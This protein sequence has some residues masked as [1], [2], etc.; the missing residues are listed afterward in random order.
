MSFCL[1]RESLKQCKKHHCAWK[2][3]VNSSY[4]KTDLKL[5]TDISWFRK[6]CSLFHCKEGGTDSSAVL[7]EPTAAFI[8]LTFV[9]LNCQS[10]SPTVLNRISRTETKTFTSMRSW[11]Q[12]RSPQAHCSCGQ[13]LTKPQTPSALP[14][15]LIM[16]ELILKLWLLTQMCYHLSPGYRQL[17]WK[18]NR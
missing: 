5:P 4:S 18:E 8:K 7:S 3:D 16:Y 10:T 1:W 12:S 17:L 2:S 6:N 9:S 15:M 11:E 13:S 14:E